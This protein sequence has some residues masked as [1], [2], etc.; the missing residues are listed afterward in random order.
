MTTEKL[1]EILSQEYLA[2]RWGVAFGTLSNWRRAGK[3]PRFIRIGDGPRAKTVYRLEDVIAY[4]KQQK[5]KA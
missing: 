4:E 2:A 5:E 1:G 3:G